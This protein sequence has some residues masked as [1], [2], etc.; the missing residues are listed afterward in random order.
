MTRAEELADKYGVTEPHDEYC[1]SDSLCRKHFIEKLEEILKK[2]ESGECG[3]PITFF[4][5][6]SRYVEV[7][8]RHG[9]PDEVLLFIRR[10]Q[11]SRRTGP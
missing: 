9:E 7:W 8:A 11:L 5:F 2:C 3:R 10:G 1:Q 4:T 6:G